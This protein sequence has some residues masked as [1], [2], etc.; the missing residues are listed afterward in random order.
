MCSLFWL[1]WLSCKYLQSDWLERF[2]WGSLVVAR[3]FS[4]KPRPKSVYDFRFSV[5]FHC[6]IVYFTCSQALHNIFHTAMTWYSLFVQKVSLNANQPT[7]LHKCW[8]VY[9]ALW[10]VCGVQMQIASLLQL[11]GVNADARHLKSVT[12]QL[13]QATGEIQ[14]LT[15]QLHLSQSEVVSSCAVMLLLAACC[16]HFLRNCQ[17]MSLLW[18]TFFWFF[19]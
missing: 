8:H 19:F 7:N 9:I 11:T 15:N 14:S 5:L 10:I 6:L 12:Q 2:L 18:I 16:L 3:I 1:F 17:K 13:S 4:T